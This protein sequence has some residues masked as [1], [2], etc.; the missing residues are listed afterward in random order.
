MQRGLFRLSSTV[1]ILFTLLLIEGAEVEATRKISGNQGKTIQYVFSGNPA[2]D[3]SNEDDLRVCKDGVIIASASPPDQ[4]DVAGITAYFVF[5]DAS[6]NIVAA[7]SVTQEYHQSARTFPYLKTTEEFTTHIY[8][9]EIVHWSTIFDPELEPNIEIF[10]R[11]RTG[12]GPTLGPFTLNIDNCSLPPENSSIITIRYTVEPSRDRTFHFTGDLGEFRLNP[13]TPEHTFTVSSGSYTVTEQRLAN[14]YLTDIF[15]DAPNHVEVEVVD[16]SLT[17][18]LTTRADVTCTFVNE[19][20]AV[21]RALKY[22]DRNGDGRRNGGEPW[23]PG[24]TFKLYS[25]AGDEVDSRATNQ[26]GK[27]S[28]PTLQ[29]GVYTLCEQQ[30]EGWVNTQPA[31]IDPDFG[32]PCYEVEVGPGQVARAHFG[33]ANEPLVA[34]AAPSGSNAELSIEPLTDT[35]DRE[36]GEDAVVTD[37]EWLN[38]AEPELAAAVYL[39]LIRR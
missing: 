2:I 5:E 6:Q 35:D 3:N 8:G 12:G 36:G 20:A 30:Q 26:F 27:V 11:V 21:I 18:N 16:R 10:Y 1:F 39:P 25:G 37:E 4:Q 13:Q 33:N 23:L 14:W 29:P 32:Q 34:S 38:T 17:L 22:H 31:T 28:F 9:I 24:W 15:C 7:E 19:R